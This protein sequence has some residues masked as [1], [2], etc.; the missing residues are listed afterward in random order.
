[1]WEVSPG[2]MQTGCEGKE[3]VD[4]WTFKTLWLVTLDLNFGLTQLATEKAFSSQIL[5]PPSFLKTSPYQ[6]ESCKRFLSQKEFPFKQK[7]FR[8]FQDMKCEKPGFSTQTTRKLFADFFTPDSFYLPRSLKGL[9]FLMLK[10]VSYLWV[11]LFFHSLFCLGF[12]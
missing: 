12:T 10:K 7:L 8:H 1:M 5:F 3:G 4:G 11:S 6:F 9:F 2:C